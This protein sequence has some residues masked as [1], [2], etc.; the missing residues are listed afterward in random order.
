M[1]SKLWRLCRRWQDS[2]CHY[3]STVLR[4][5]GN[6]AKFDDFLEHMHDRTIQATTAQA[7]FHGATA[8][9]DPQP[10]IA[11]KQTFF[12]LFRKF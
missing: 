6:A 8:H 4:F 10:V 1:R 5:S 2:N 7:G 9:A 11:T 3:I 12:D